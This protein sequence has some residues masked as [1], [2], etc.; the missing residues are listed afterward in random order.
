[1]LIYYDLKQLQIH[2]GAEGTF[3]PPPPPPKIRKKEQVFWFHYFSI[4][5]G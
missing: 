5:G 4:F 2:S 3:A 1:M